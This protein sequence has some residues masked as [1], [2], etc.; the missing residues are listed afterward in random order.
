[1][2]KAAILGLAF[3]LAGCGGSG[4]SS[5]LEGSSGTVGLSFANATNFN[6]STA[7]LT[8]YSALSGSANGNSITISIANG[9]R[10]IQTFFFADSVSPGT[11]VDLSSATGSSVVYSDAQ[12]T[13]NASSGT[14]RVDSKTPTSV[15]LTLSNVV[16]E[17]S[18]GGA[19]GSAVVSG[20]VAFVA[21]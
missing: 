17:N 10:S 14:L 16:L 1:M 3:L 8:S 19:T 15:Q 4:T 18:S 2:N 21:G 12:G 20:T 9:P 13:W 11:T 5:L 6:G 7:D